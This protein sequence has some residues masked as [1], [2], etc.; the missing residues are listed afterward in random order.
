MASETRPIAQTTPNMPQP[1]SRVYLDDCM[2]AMRQMPDK[3]FDIA[4][5]D[6]PYG[7]REHGGK[8]R[9][10]M[11]LQK[12]GARLYVADGGYAKKQWDFAPPLRSIS[13]NSAAYQRPKSFG[14]STIS[15]TRSARAASFGINAMAAATNPTVKSPF[16]A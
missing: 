16:A 12:N 6:P 3:A 14:A 13:R 4:I 8:S 15:P 9:S 11:V 1:S 10:G 5:V 2:V 7:R